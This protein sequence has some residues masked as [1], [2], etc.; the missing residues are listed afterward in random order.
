MAFVESAKVAARLESLKRDEGEEEEGEAQRRRACFQPFE[1]PKVEK[2]ATDEDVREYVMAVSECYDVDK[3][4]KPS[5]VVGLLSATECCKESRERTF[6]LER[7]ITLRWL[8]HAFAEARRGSD[9]EGEEEEGP[10][11]SVIDGL[12]LRRECENLR[13]VTKTWTP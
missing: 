3:E 5:L 8:K 2:K 4:M 11:F 13:A 7:P 1:G 9:D 6:R 12:T 10:L